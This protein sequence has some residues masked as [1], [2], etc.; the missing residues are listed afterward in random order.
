MKDNKEESIM[1]MFNLPSYTKGKTFA[2]ASEA[3]NKKFKGQNDPDS[4]NTLKELQ[5]RLQ[6]AQEYIKKQ[7]E[8]TPTS[9]NPDPMAP[10]GRMSDQSEQ[11]ISEEAMGAAGGQSPGANIM[12]AM[13]AN[14]GG[15]PNQYFL[16]GLLGAKGD[17]PNAAGIAGMATTALDLG[18]TAFGKP[19]IDTSGI[20]SAPDVQSKG[21]AAAGGAMKGAQ[22][23]MSFGP[24]GAAIGGVVGGVAGLVGRGKQ[25]DAANEA[26]INNAGAMDKQFNN[27]Y[28]GGGSLRYLDPLY[29]KPREAQFKVDL[30]PNNMGMVAAPTLQDQMK[31][32]IEASKGV[33]STFDLGTQS[34]DTG[35]KF[36]PGA[37]LRYAPA[38]TNALQ[39]ATLKKPAQESYDRLGNVYNEQRVDERSL[40]NVV[41]QDVAGMRDRIVNASGGSQGAARA[42][43]I[44]SQLQG[45]KALSDAYMN[46]EGV[47][48]GESQKAQD[49]KFNVDRTNLG[50]SNMEIEANARNQGAYDTQKSKLMA[51]LGDDL[52]GIGQEE[53]FKQYPELMG[54]DYNTRGE[55]LAKIKA[56]KEKKDAARKVAKMAR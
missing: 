50:Q 32:N 1:K 20:S 43:L 47:N 7:S 30:R 38:A 25:A 52:G 45:T 10:A 16:G 24:W 21:G 17:M 55:Y 23:G 19:N 56:D 51:Q 42:S 27:T 8:P 22:A 4:Q 39:L 3:I 26:A 35:A 15:G 44:A 54:M 53:L 11:N 6:Q 28:E 9:V 12:G 48:R 33:A 18:R 2:E 31:S 41:G 29:A 46:A 36:N 13:G 49:F 14:D 37:L 40:Q 5:T 34:T